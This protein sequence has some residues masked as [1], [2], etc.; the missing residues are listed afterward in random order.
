MLVKPCFCSGHKLVEDDTVV[1][2]LTQKTKVV[3]FDHRLEGGRPRSNEGRAVRY[4]SFQNSRLADLFRSKNH[5]QWVHQ[6]P[7][8]PPY[9]PA[10]QETGLT[11]GA[12]TRKVNAKKESLHPKA[13]A[14]SEKPSFP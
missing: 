8:S 3:D 4:S 12:S 11:L 13:E 5:R 6:V 14:G 7:Y 10:G 1:Q 9:L 2:V